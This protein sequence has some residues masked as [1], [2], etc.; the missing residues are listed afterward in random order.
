MPRFSHTVTA[1]ASIEDAWVT[2]QDAG[3][4]GSLLGAAEVGDISVEDGLLQG[5][6]WTAK[7]GGTTLKGTMTVETST[8]VD[9]MDVMVRT[10]EW[11]CRIE[12]VL[13]DQESNDPETEVHSRV[14]LSADGLTAMLALPVVSNVIGKYFPDRLQDLAEMMAE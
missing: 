12:M 11:R 13:T 5:A 1:A 4:W 3:V 7:I 6:S 14:H 10:S 8:P 9:Y 2:L